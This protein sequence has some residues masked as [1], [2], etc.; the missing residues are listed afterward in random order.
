[1][2]KKNIGK[3]GSPATA[4]KLGLKTKQMDVVM[5]IVSE[6]DVLIKRCRKSLLWHRL[7]RLPA[8]T[9]MRRFSYSLSQV[10]GIASLQPR[11]NGDSVAVAAHV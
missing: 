4:L 10:R 6:R 8:L 2:I 9:T 3:E 5:G 11:H 1:M 7:H